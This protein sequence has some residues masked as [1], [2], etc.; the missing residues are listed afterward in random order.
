MSLDINTIKDVLS[1]F[2]E[3]ES[4]AEPDQKIYYL[5]CRYHNKVSTRLLKK[6]EDLRILGKKEFGEQLREAIYR[7][8]PFL[9]LIG[10]DPYVGKYYPV[11]ISK[12]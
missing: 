1:E 11:P 6:K 7:P 10:K 9:S 5:I 3:V 12:T 4:L 8:N 2:Y